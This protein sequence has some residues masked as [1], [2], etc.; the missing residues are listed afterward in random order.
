[1]EKKLLTE[2]YHRPKYA[3]LSGYKELGGYKVLKKALS[4]KKRGFDLRG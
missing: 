1:M 4:M 2:H 3:T